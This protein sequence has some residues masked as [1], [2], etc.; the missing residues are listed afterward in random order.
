M[1]CTSWERHLLISDDAMDIYLTHCPLVRAN[2]RATPSAWPEG[3]KAVKFHK[4]V[5]QRLGLIGEPD[6]NGQGRS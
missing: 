1:S 3:K 4:L 2:P 6:H 5:A